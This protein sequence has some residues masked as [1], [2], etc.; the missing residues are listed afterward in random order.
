MLTWISDIFLK[1]KEKKKPPCVCRALSGHM[2]QQT[3]D[4]YDGVLWLSSPSCVVRGSSWDQGKINN[5][6]GD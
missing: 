1:K 5:V 2:L 3:R 4:L 6:K